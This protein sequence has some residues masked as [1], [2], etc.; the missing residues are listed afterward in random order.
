MGTAIKLPAL[1]T[2]PAQLMQFFSGKVK[3]M[4]ARF[5]CGDKEDNIL[6]EY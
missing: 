5:L 4:H 3:R 2:Q 6:H 1:P